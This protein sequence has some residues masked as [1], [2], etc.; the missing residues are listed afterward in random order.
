MGEKAITIVGTQGVNFSFPFFQEPVTI[1]QPDYE[2]CLHPPPSSTTLTVLP[3]FVDY[4]G[5]IY[6]HDFEEGEKCQA[7]NRKTSDGGFQE[8]WSEFLPFT[9]GI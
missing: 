8:L 7:N 4:E 3:V 6:A 1:V 2:V 5:I 9:F